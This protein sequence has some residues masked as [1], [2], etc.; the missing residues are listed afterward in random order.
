MIIE[1]AIG[2]YYYYGYYII[3]NIG[4]TIGLWMEN[5][6]IYFIIGLIDNRLSMGL[7]SGVI[8]RGKL[9]NHV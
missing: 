5:Y 8:K 2:Y 7:P 6:G 9:W 3:G 4:K 1:K